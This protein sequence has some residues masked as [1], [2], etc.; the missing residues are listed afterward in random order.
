[1]ILAVINGGLGLQISAN[2]KGGEIAYGV[3]AGVVAVAYAA[4]TIFKR[5]GV[6]TKWDGG[7]EKVASREV[8]RDERGEAGSEARGASRSPS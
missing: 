6:E 7:R 1:M 8:S 4:I 2:T 3:I 5:K